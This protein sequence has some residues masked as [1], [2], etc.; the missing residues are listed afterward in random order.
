MVRNDI[1]FFFFKSFEPALNKSRDLLILLLPCHGNYSQ[2]IAQPPP[3]QRQRQPATATTTTTTTKAITVVD[4]KPPRVFFL[5][6]SFM[7]YLFFYF[8][9][10]HYLDHLDDDDDDCDNHT[11]QPLQ[12][13]PRPP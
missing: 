11:H 8:S 7:L 13:D 12:P 9:Y 5:L 3:R 4:G 1:E 2:L 10:Y 6:I